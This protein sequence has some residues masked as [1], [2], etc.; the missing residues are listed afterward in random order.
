MNSFINE[1]LE[2]VSA[3]KIGSDVLNIRELILR[4]QSDQIIMFSTLKDEQVKYGKLI[5]YA[6]KYTFNITQKTIL[7]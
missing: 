6:I 5:F 7:L 3:C 2:P 4:K 1:E